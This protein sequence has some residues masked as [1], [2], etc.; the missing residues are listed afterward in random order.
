MTTLLAALLFSARPDILIADFEQAG[1]GAWRATGTAFGTAPARG[2]LANQMLV[3]GFRGRGLVN[4]Y[5]GG[6]GATG[7]LTS[8]PFTIQ[9]RGI[10]FLLGGGKHPGETGI[11]LLINGELVASSTG[12]STTP[13]DTETLRWMSW[14][15]SPWE[16]KQAR[17]QI[18][19]TA[20][21]GWGHI[22]VDEIHQS[23]EMKKDEPAAPEPLYQEKFRPQFHFSAKKNWLNDPNGMVYYDGEYHL[24]FQYT[25]DSLFSGIKS[26]GHAVSPDLVHWRELPVAI[27]PDEHGA[28]WS[29]SA[30]MD[31]AGTAGFGKDGHPAMI[32]LYTAAGDPF[33]QR[34]AYSLDKGRTFTKHPEAVLPHVAGENRDPR[35][36]WHE[37][38]GK[39]IMALY[40]TGIEFALY[41]SPDLKSWTELSRLTLP[42]SGECPEL[43]EMKIEG[44]DETRWIF[45]GADYHYLIGQFN[46]TTFTPESGPH[47]GDHNPTFYA[48]QTF[49]NAPD[50]RTIQIAWMRGNGPFPGMPY[51]Q[52][53]SFPCDLR[54]VQTPDGLRVVRH[55]VAEIEQLY[56]R[57]VEQTLK[58]DGVKP[59]EL[60]GGQYD[61]HLQVKTDASFGLRMANDE[62][63][64]D[65]PTRTLT[66]LD[67]SAKVPE[68]D[69][70]DL[71]ILVD[72][73]S[74][75]V[76][77]AGGRVSF[78][79]YSHPTGNE[80]PVELFSE[81]GPSQVS[82]QAHELKSGW[83]AE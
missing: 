45:Y 46:G 66:V 1:Y 60:N 37:P 39:W 61:I 79:T 71:R 42:G 10:N 80:M 14:D 29:G 53:M 49:T 17:I 59:L 72:R 35:I 67:R 76:F 62:I 74:I 55:P 22:N 57:K 44:T 56:G 24:F 3:T 27:W 48:S 19:D 75:E 68:M 52:Q 15:V 20:T 2:T 81:G 51:N 38:S 7:T 9:R 34:L 16:G 64:Y 78:T 33:T 43:F 25:H 8:P 47:I 41:G 21:G 18:I 82:V 50:G 83:A 13:Q 11:N 31:W 69:T 54:L 63:R 32:A 73:T 30:A 5:L 65:A 36:F 12:T 23:D 58:L 77:A 4:T 6:D 70:L 28:I 26:W 40:L